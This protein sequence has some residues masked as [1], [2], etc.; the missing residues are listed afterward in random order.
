VSTTEILQELPRL[1]PAERRLVR[2]VLVELATNE[3]DVY[4]CD[5][6]AT[7]AAMMFDRMEE[8]AARSKQ[9]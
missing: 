3:E 7:E 5:Q 8:E 4:L 1:S 6:A 9:R 2:R